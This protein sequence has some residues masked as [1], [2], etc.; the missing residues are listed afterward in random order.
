MSLPS[1]SSTPGGITVAK[2][3][4]QRVAWA[5]LVVVILLV[6]RPVPAD[7]DIL[8]G[9][10]RIIGGVLEVPRATLAGTFSGPPILGTAV[11]LLSGTLNGL[12]MVAGGALETVISAI[13]FA[14]K[15]A[16]LI[17]VFL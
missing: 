8:R 16:P 1:R 17:P 6:A 3:Q 15:L 11:G 4:S 5:T 13:P 7:A 10:L 2:P 14:A 12:G 9:L